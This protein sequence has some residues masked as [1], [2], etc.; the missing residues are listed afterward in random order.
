MLH[1]FEFL[2][3]T[4]SQHIKKLFAIIII[5]NEAIIEMRISCDC[6]LFQE[7]N[8]IRIK[9]INYQIFLQKLFYEITNN[10]KIDLSQSL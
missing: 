3:K 2:F 10:Y 8:R 5:I 7:K 6:L 4:Q 9:I 1:I